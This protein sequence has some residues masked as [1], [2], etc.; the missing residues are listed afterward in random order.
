MANLVFWFTKA[1]CFISQEKYKT[2][3][4]SR[5]FDSRP[6]MVGANNGSYNMHCSRKCWKNQINY[7]SKRDK[8]SMA[9]NTLIAIDTNFSIICNCL[10]SSSISSNEN[11]FGRPSQ[12]CMIESL[13]K[14]HLRCYIFTEKLNNNV[15]IWTTKF[16]MLL[17]KSSRL[18]QVN[19]K[20][21]TISK[22]KCWVD[23]WQQIVAIFN[24][25]LHEKLLLQLD[26]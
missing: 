14:Y 10:L 16:I 1:H 23:F 21:N 17:T 12:L 24:A 18:I 8:K 13:K 3:S 5:N 2:S 9:I 25:L 26:P 20:W 19:L 22:H 11:M 15:F 6:V 7:F 4:P